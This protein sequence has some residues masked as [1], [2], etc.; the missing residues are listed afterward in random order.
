M[1][2]RW[3][4]RSRRAPQA[5]RAACAKALGVRE[6]GVW[7]ASVSVATAGS[8]RCDMRPEV[9]TRDRAIQGL[10]GWLSLRQER[11]ATVTRRKQR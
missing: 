2:G 10:V 8:V 1:S 3:W 11:W 7:K 4:R 5:V 9:Q 6:R